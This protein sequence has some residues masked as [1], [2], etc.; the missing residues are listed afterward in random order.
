MPLKLEID[1]TPPTD[2]PADWIEDLADRIL[3]RLRCR[4]EHG[5]NGYQM[6]GTLTLVTCRTCGDTLP[7][8][9]LEEDM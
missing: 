7:D 9:P 6:A 1:D 4:H 2:P 3:E 8:I 5:V